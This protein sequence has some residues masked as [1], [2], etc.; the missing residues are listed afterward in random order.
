MVTDDANR[1]EA[2]SRLK[3]AM[4]R[5]RDMK[6]RSESG[7]PMP[8]E[9]DPSEVPGG[10]GETR[11]AGVSRPR[12]S[13]PGAG[14]DYRQTRVEMA[15]ERALQR[16]KVVSRF[17]HEGISD[18]VKI[19][20]TQILNKMDEIG[21]NTLLVTSANP[22][23]GKTFTSINLAVSLCQE[24]G[25]TTLLVDTDLRKPEVARAFGLD[26]SAGLSDYLL[27][28][29]TVPCLLVNPGIPKLT[30]LPGGVALPN[31]TE[32]LGSPRMEALVEEMKT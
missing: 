28:T 8:M 22:Q 12:R 1:T 6:L 24:V 7:S 10:A 11:A 13:T 27:G 4:E 18:Q 16:G 26:G 17:H 25:R 29:A 5:A 3:R 2:M 21:G 20:R 23:E 31:S 19:L 9:Q 30:L 15:S 32:L 14:P